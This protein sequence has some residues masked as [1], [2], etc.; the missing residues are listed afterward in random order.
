M[1]DVELIMNFNVY[2]RK[3]SSPNLWYCPE[4]V[5]GPEENHENISHDSRS[6]DT[7]LTPDLQNME[8][9]C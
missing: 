8:Y 3:W 1:M 7:D 9:E 2:G 5:W 6:A 4:F